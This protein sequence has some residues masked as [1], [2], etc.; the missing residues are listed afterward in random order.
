[1]LKI[2]SYNAP[3]SCNSVIPMLLGQESTNN[4]PTARLKLVKIET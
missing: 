3:V 4:K 2:G 1:M